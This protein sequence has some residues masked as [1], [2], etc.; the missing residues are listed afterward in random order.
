M[1]ETGFGTLDG[2]PDLKRAMKMLAVG[3]K[4]QADP[5]DRLHL[6]KKELKRRAL[7]RL[8]KEKAHRVGAV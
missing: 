7:R 5:I 8:Q 2:E 4:M 1:H 6:R 3:I